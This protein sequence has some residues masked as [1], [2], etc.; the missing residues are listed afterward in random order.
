MDQQA[1]ALLLT[2]RGRE[3]LELA[4]RHDGVITDLQVGRDELE[5]L[6]ELGFLTGGKGGIYFTVKSEEGSDAA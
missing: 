6:K 1:R 5:R 2:D 3:V 4:E